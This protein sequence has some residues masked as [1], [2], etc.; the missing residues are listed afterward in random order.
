MYILNFFSAVPSFVPLNVDAE[1]LNATHALLSWDP[2]PPEH[3]NGVIE[4]YHITIKVTETGELLQR[5]ST[6]NST[7]IGQLHPFYTYMFSVAAQTVAVGPFSS[8]ITLKMPEAGMFSFYYC[9]I[10]AHTL[11]PNL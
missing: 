5:F 4:Q 11:F 8:Q 9:H 1:S 10:I 7:V 2:P 3:Q 6:Y